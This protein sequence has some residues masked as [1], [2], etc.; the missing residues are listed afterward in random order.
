MKN[1]G[2]KIGNKQSPIDIIPSQAAFDSSLK[3]LK[4]SY[5]DFKDASLLNNGLTVQFAPNEAGNTSSKKYQ[6][7]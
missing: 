3:N 2:L 5:P 1:L 6:F 4:F 7:A